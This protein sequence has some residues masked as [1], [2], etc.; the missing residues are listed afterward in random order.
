MWI[1][2][3][4]LD[5]L[6]L[7]VPKTLDDVRRVAEAF[8][9][10]DPDGNG[11]DDTVGLLFQKDM[12]GWTG[13]QHFLA[14]YHGYHQGWVKDS[15]GSL[16]YAAIQPQVKTGLTALADWYQKGLVNRDWSQM[17]DEEVYAAVLSSRTGIFFGVFYAPLQIVQFE[18]MNPGGKLYA[19]PLPSADSTPSKLM[20]SNPISGYYVVNK[21]FQNPEALIKLANYTEEFYYGTSGIREK[22]PYLFTSPATGGENWYHMQLGSLFRPNKNYDYHLIIREV[23]RTGNTSTLNSESTGYYEW[24]KK[25][26]DGDRSEGFPWAYA[27]IFG[28]D[29][30]SYTAIEDYDKNNRILMDAYSG[31]PT[32]S[33]KTRLSSLNS[34]RDEIFTKIIIGELPAGAFDTFVTDWKRQGGDDI[35]SEVNAWYR[36]NNK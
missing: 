23:M 7:P 25:W 21:K 19:Y 31:P 5:K 4:W 34:L 30:A 1:R 36:E 6:G 20:V 2:Q 28:P 35:T 11:K 29:Q 18:Q 22:R 14:A 27:F 33:M 26:Y 15:S 16:A 12:W 8:I 3:D 24:I 17:S 13:V 32:D 9:T 10:R